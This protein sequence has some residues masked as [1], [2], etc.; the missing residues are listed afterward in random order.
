MDTLLLLL[1]SVCYRNETRPTLNPWTCKEQCH[2]NPH[3]YPV[4]CTRT[5]QRSLD[6]K[7]SPFLHSSLVL[8]CVIQSPP[9]CWDHSSSASPGLTGIRTHAPF[10]G[11]HLQVPTCQGQESHVH[12]SGLANHTKSSRIS[13]EGSGNVG[14]PHGFQN[15]AMWA[16]GEHWH[17]PTCNLGAGLELPNFCL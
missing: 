14:P 11:V 5:S 1:F 13:A 16:E 3:P 17:A 9:R 2:F 6:V 8:K 12:N 10:P 4:L 7:L 15:L